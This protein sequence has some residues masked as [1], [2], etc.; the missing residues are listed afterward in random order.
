MTLR[1]KVPT[2]L[3]LAPVAAEIDANLEPLRDKSPTEIDFELQLEFKG[4]LVPNTREE[5][6]SAILA[7]ALR[8]VNRHGWAA[9]ITDDACRLRLTGGSV[10]LDLGLSA[11]ILRFVETGGQGGAQVTAS[12]TV[13]RTAGGRS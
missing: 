10:S 7:T 9:E 4:P 8:D 5:R 13:Q 11:N 1:P 6:E 12:P 3:S 2:D